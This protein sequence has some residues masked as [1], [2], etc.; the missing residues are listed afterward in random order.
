MLNIVIK[1][2][3]LIILIPFYLM[4]QNTNVS[5]VATTSATFL[6]IP[7]GAAAVGMGGA[8][9]S[10]ANDASALYWNVGGISTIGKYD[11]QFANM[12]WIGDTRFNFA[13]LVLP[14]GE[15]GNPWLKFHISFYG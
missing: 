5:K 12:E 7:V 14:L 8:F 11:L 4:G 15:F 1:S 2:I 9:V 13:G 10:L 3:F 6:E